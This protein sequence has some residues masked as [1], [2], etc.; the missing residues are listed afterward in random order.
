MT[1]AQRMHGLGWLTALPEDGPATEAG[2]AATAAGAARPLRVVIAGGGTGGHLFPGIAVAEEIRAR[3]P[4]NRVLFVSRG[5]DFERSAL[6]RAGFPLEAITVEGLKGRGVWNQLRALYHLPHAV[7]QSARIVRAFGPDLVIGLGSYAAGPVVMAAWLRR[8]P[9]ALCE[10]NTLP[11]IANRGL[12]PLAD[13]IYTAFERTGGGFDPRKVLWTGN[14]LRREI[15]QA[16]AE[17][18]RDAAATRGEKFTVLVIGGSQGAHGI[19]VAVA[20]ALGR[21]HPRNRF[22][23]VHQT[24]TAD[25]D[26]VREAYRRAGIPG[27][28]QAFYD[29][30]A[31]Q[32]GRTDLVICRAGATTVAE[33]TALGK[34][35]IFIPF[36]QAADDHQRLNAL[37]LVST[38]AAE[39]ITE[40]ELSGVRLAERIA[41]FASHPEALRDLAEKSARL[42]KPDAA[43]RIVDDCVELI[44]RRTGQ[45]ANRPTG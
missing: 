14:P 41:F 21:L 22:D 28:V 43:R 13:R 25:E 2:H 3:N 29:D 4:R 5:N 19:N 26:M 33:I 6:A 18:H 9:V 27:R 34:A 24:G 12:A 8:R 40:A 39:M 11:G 31:A 7:L 42:G 36:P 38:G 16:A 20:E 45:R 15:V 35:A 1:T 17:P 23:F 10:Q 32:Y 44:A 30:M 37:C